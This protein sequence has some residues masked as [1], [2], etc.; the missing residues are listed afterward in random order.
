MHHGF[1][2]RGLLVA[3]H[4]ACVGSYAGNTSSIVTDPFTLALEVSFIFIFF[5][6]KT[7]QRQSQQEEAHKWD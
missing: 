2:L 3:I 6:K 7:E 1:H 5:K 4:H